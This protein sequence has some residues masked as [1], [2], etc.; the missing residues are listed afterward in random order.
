MVK[1]I[2][3]KKVLTDEETQALL[4]Q[5]LPKN[6][7]KTVLTEDADVY[8]ED[9][10]LLLKFRKGVLPQL[11]TKQAYENLIEFAKTMTTNRGTVSGN[12]GV[13]N[14]LNNDPV[15][16]NIIGY[17][18]NLSPFYK[19]VLKKAGMKLPKCRETAFT[20]SEP[21]KWELVIPLI[22]DIDKQYKKLFPEHHSKQ[23]KVCQA[24]K[25]KIG[26]TAFSTVTTNLNLQTAVHTDKGDFDEGFG[27]L[28]VIERGNYRGGFT[29]FPQYGMAV[30]VRTGDFLGMDVHEPHGN[31][32]LEGKEG[33]YQRLSLVSYLRKNM[34][35]R[36]KGEPI[37]HTSYFD[38]ARE[39]LKKRKDKEGKKKKFYGGRKELLKKIKGGR[40]VKK[41]SE[42]RV[43][44]K[45]VRRGSK[46]RII[47]Y[48]K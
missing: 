48:Y 13:K 36:C 15:M 20:G 39:I 21:H 35:K 8:K 31:T 1:V 33:E 45:M 16:S 17:F 29:G 18:D 26:N 14:T 47:K 28:V 11:H 38:K 41:E 4:G 10:T 37:T 32:P 22:E 12:M 23:H 5:K 7:Y 44:Y 40:I 9:G 34:I 43:G 25:Y 3:A 19:Y 24:T 42:K 27:N 2:H 30:D 6:Y 46:K